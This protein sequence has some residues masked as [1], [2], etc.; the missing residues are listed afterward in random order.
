VLILIVAFA[1]SGIAGLCRK[2]W[3]HFTAVK[4]LQPE[5]SHD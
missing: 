2:V 5:E 1:P 3:Q 4:S